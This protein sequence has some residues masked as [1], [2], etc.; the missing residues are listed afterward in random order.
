[1]NKKYVRVPYYFCFLSSRFPAGLFQSVWWD[2][3]LYR[4]EE[5]TDRQIKRVWFCFL[6]GFCYSWSHLVIQEPCH[7]WQ[8]CKLCQVT[9]FLHYCMGESTSVFIQR[10]VKLNCAYGDLRILTISR[11][12]INIFVSI[13]FCNL[14][15]SIHPTTCRSMFS[16]AN[17]CTLVAGSGENCCELA[18][19]LLYT[20]EKSRAVR[21]KCCVC[22]RA[23]SFLSALTKIWKTNGSGFRRL[24]RTEYRFDTDVESS[25]SRGL[26]Q[27]N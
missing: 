4:H 27:K 18:G 22:Q 26:Q 11:I 20:S 12:K 23:M 5:S 19:S 13:S 16:E 15:R 3:R 7:R 17:A 24:T 10:F 1:M 25:M 14:V 8:N 6:Q 9:T 2:H 21:K